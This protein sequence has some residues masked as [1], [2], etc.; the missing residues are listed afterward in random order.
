MRTRSATIH[1]WPSRRFDRSSHVEV[2]TN[3]WSAPST[4]PALLGPGWSTLR[5]ARAVQFFQ[6]ALTSLTAHDRFGLGPISGWR[7]R[8]RLGTDP[9]VANTGSLA[10]RPR[11]LP[12]CWR[13][14]FVAHGVRVAPYVR[15]RQPEVWLG[16]S[17]SWLLRRVGESAPVGTAAGLLCCRVVAHQGS[18]R[19][20]PKC[21]SI[22]RS[23]KRVMA[24]IRAPSRV[25]TN[26]PRA[27]AMSARGSL[28]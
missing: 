7:L 21:G 14:Q 13:R 6:P 4:V 18:V 5:S 2:S 28:W 16:S 11:A 3:R 24:E 25:R 20:S 12:S 1:R 15:L 26:T 19:G 22:A 9:Q 23:P 8:W 10:S 27:W 17:N